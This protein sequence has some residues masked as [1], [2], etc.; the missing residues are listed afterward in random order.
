MRRR[1]ATLGT[2]LIALALAVATLTALLPTPAG[3]LD[4]PTVTVTDDASTAGAGGGAVV[5]GGSF[6]FSATVSPPSG[7]STTPTGTVTWSNL[8]G[9]NNSCSTSTLDSSGVATCTVTNVQAG[10]YTATA[11][12]NGD[13][14]YAT[15]QGSDTTATVGPA[16]PSPSTIKIT[17]LPQSGIFGGGFTA[18]ITT[19]N[20]NGDQSVASATPNVCATSGLT[21]N[22]IGVGICS[23]SAQIAANSNYL[24]A[25]GTAQTF[26]IAQAIPTTP[27]ISNLPP[28]GQPEFTGFTANLATNGDGTPSVTSS[29]PIVCQVESDGLTVLLQAT[30]ACTLTPS[31][32]NGTNFVG[33]TGSPQTFQVGGAPRGYWLVGSDG[34]IFSFGAA[35]FFGSMGGTPLQRPVVGI[36]PTL[37][38]DGYWLVA[39][40]GGIFSFG[41]AGFYGSIPGLGLHPA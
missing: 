32:A 16:T 20:S 34:G 13:S 35:P 2:G 25:S 39:S 27:S 6:T 1:F 29:T 40:D 10:T 28:S 18:D 4:T 31:V 41:D 38:R 15:A 24:S 30:G 21:V 7:D 5:T 23:I 17:N 8:T 12:Y 22:Y 11:T 37:T 36:T 26:N 3:A 19:T 33:A 14:N 9:F